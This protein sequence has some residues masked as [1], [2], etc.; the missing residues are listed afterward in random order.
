MSVSV[1][2]YLVRYGLMNHVGAFAADDDEAPRGRGRKVVI[3]TGRGVEMGEVLAPVAN[4]LTPTEPPGPIL[5]DVGPLDE[6]AARRGEQDRER[7]FELCRQVIDQGPWPIVPI[8]LEALIEPGRSVLYVLGPDEFDPT[9]LKAAAWASHGLDL[10]VEPA[11]STRAAPRP[12]AASGCGGC[13]GCGSGGC[14]TTP[15]S[16]AGSTLTVL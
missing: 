7:L 11:R 16:H 15:V 2:S 4:A 5:R 1:R 9:T 12:K 13:T 10:V 6:E 8:D 14:G 3:R